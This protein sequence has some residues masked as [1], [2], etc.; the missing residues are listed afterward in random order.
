MAF[1]SLTDINQGQ[2][3]ENEALQQHDKNVEDGPHR[4]SQNMAYAQAKAC[5][6]K[7]RP[8]AA[9]QG[10]QHENQFTG[11]HVA[12]QP[13]TKRY[14]L[15]R[16][17]NEI[18][19]QVCRCQHD[20]RNTF[21]CKGGAEQFLDKTTRVFDLDAVVQ[22]DQQHTQGHAHG[23]VQVGR[24]QNTVVVHWVAVLGA[25]TRNLENP[26]HKINRDQVKC[27]HEDNPQKHSEGQRRYKTAAVLVGNNA[28]GLVFDHVDQHFD[29]HLEAP[30]HT[31]RHASSSA[32]EEEQDDHTHKD[33]P[34]QR[35]VVDDAEIGDGRLFFTYV[36]KMNQVMLDVVR[37]GR[38]I[39]SGSHL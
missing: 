12:E 2:H 10:D 24:W 7:A 27:V 29:R 20:S 9:K 21:S 31:S 16:V 36:I 32:P 37:L 17:L 18:H 5:T 4:A 14:R 19:E 25:Q 39:S 33:G 28:L 3:H 30:R 34:E 6:I 13:H 38:N 22:H 26:R 8:C 1:V 23:D 35:V 11:E 15:G